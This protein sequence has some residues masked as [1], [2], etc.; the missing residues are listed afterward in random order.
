MNTRKIYPSLSF[1]RSLLLERIHLRKIISEKLKEG[2]SSNKSKNIH[3]LNLLS[4]CYKEVDKYKNSEN[5]AFSRGA[6][7][8]S[9]AAGDGCGVAFT[10][11]K[12]AELI[13]RRGKYHLKKYNLAVTSLQEYDK[14]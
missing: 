14:M 5:F 4:T 12:R 8:V 1:I 13:K 2:S 9:I 7:V 11:K 6:V 10:I 3:I